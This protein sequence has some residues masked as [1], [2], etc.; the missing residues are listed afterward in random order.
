MG[1]GSCEKKPEGPQRVELQGSTMG[2]SYHIK[3]IRTPNATQA[4]EVEEFIQ[5]QLN[6]LNGQMSTY[7]ADSDLSRFNADQGKTRWEFPFEAKEVLAEAL[8]IG[9]D[10]GGALDV[11]VGPLVELWGFGKAERKGL[12]TAGEIAQAKALTGL[13]KLSLKEGILEVTEPRLQVDLS[14]IAKGYAVDE[15]AGIL[16]LFGFYDYMVEIGGEVKVRGRKIDGGKWVI[17]IEKPDETGRSVH[18]SIALDGLAIAT[19]GDYRNFFRD[20][21]K[22]YSH[23]IDPATGRPVTHDLASVTVIHPKC[24]VADG[25]ATALMVA[26]PEKAKELAKKNGLAVMLLIKRGEGFEEWQSESFEAVGQGG[27]APGMAAPHK[28]RPVLPPGL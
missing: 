4:S 9:R 23:M 2:T 12:P 27:K 20:Q 5:L 10:S 1:L 24:S 28:E 17:G 14:S 22:K 15:V 16:E 25:W 3:F 18:S 11:T 21:G 6:A 19:S 8:L 7:Q 26:G 13:D